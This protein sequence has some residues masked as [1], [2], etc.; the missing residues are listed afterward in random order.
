MTAWDQSDSRTR[1]LLERYQ[2]RIYIA[3]DSYLPLDFYDDYLPWCRMMSSSTDEVFAKQVSSTWL[4]KYQFDSDKRLDYLVTPE[5]ALAFTKKDVHPTVYGRVYTDKLDDVGLVFLK[6]SLVYPYS[7]LP[8]ENGFWK[9]LG[10]K[11]IG[12]PKAWHELDIHGAIHVVLRE[13]TMQ[14]LGIIL[15][16]HNHHRLHLIGKTLEWPKDGHI[17]ISVAQL[18][19]EPY[20]MESGGAFRLERTVG[21][22]T[23]IEYLLGVTDDAPLGSG[24]D[25]VY[26]VEGSAKEVETQLQLLP[27]DD[28]LYVA[29]IAMG[30]EYKVFGIWKTWYMRGP[31]G[32]D[33]YTWPELKNLADLMAFWNVDIKDTRFFELLKADVKSFDDYDLS[34]VLDLQREELIGTLKTD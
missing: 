31:P 4:K 17:S 12:D 22:P 11:I 1:E 26:T 28:P 13:E 33:F 24:F 14:P 21:N 10:S 34:R 32:M 23:E 6:Y 25:K 15:A 29:Q 20:L 8:A 9:R 30:D 5:R 3:P 16:Q 7:G 19:N 18:S 2:P 27:L